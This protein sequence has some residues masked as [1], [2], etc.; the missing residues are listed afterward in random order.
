MKN[1]WK[2]DFMLLILYSKFIEKLF[3]FFCAGSDQFMNSKKISNNLRTKT[4]YEERKESDPTCRL[5]T[6][7][8]KSLSYC[9]DTDVKPFRHHE[10]NS[11]VTKD[12][13]KVVKKEDHYQNRLNS[14]QS[15]NNS[16]RSYITLEPLIR[17]KNTRN[18]D[19]MITTLTCK[20]STYSNTKTQT[21]TTNN[22]DEYGLNKQNF[23]ERLKNI[24]ISVKTGD[25]EP[26]E[27]IVEVVKERKGDD[28]KVL[29]STDLTVA[30][31]R[32]DAQCNISSESRLL[33]PPITYS[34]IQQKSNINSLSLTNTSPLVL[35][36]DAVVKSKSGPVDIFKNHSNSSFPQCSNSQSNSEES[37]LSKKVTLQTSG[38][39]DEDDD[40]DGKWE[41]ISDDEWE[42]ISEEEVE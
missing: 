8:A 38:G 40:E 36:K 4:H 5:L 17:N 11:V 30:Y 14:N 16:N 34:L 37:T 1:V 20:V 6:K 15:N 18:D 21:V 3:F 32:T 25:N 13:K 19:K 23:N 35:H 9:G 39:D 22:R 24:V 41:D 26:S 31:E 2:C 12:E 42:D 28:S 27:R 10:A 29:S 7:Q 33:S